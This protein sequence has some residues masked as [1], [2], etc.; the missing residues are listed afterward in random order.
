MP[1]ED[2]LGWLRCIGE[3][4]ESSFRN[5]GLAK[6]RT[7]LKLSSTRANSSRNCQNL[8]GPNLFERAPNLA[9]TAPTLVEM[10]HAWVEA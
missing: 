4:G 8:A 9:E 10:A 5:E 2:A 1:A 3:S 6:S 7:M